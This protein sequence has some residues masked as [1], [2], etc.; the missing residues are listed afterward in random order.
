M[1]RKIAYWVTTV[2]LAVGYLIG[3]FA[4]LVQL[5]GFVEQ[6]AKL[7]YPL[8]FFRILGFWKLVGAVVILL[9]GLPRAKEW[10]YA[11]FVI[12][13]TAA[14]VTHVSIGDPPEESI[15]SAVLLVFAVASWALR[16]ESRRLAGPCV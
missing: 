9:P 15:P 14:S 6:T 13:L 3:G 8:L 4:D 7:G 2:L 11:G 16:P 5:E 12:N 10:A 1:A